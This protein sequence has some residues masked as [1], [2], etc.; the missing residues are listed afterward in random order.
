VTPDGSEVLQV[1]H[2]AGSEHSPSWSPDSKRL[3][4]SRD[5]DIWVMKR[6]GSN[7][8]NITNTATMEAHPAWSR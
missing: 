6:D 7:P 3:A 8:I 1:T 4:Y 5:G 2:T